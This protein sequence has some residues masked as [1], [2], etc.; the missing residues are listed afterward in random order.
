MKIRIAAATVLIAIAGT[1]GAGCSTDDAVNAVT[2][3]VAEVT[4]STAT[5]LSTA[6]RKTREA[7]TNLQQEAKT[8]PPAAL[9][10]ANATLDSV[11]SSLSGISIPEG[12][13]TAWREVVGDFSQVGDTIDSGVAGIRES[14]AGQQ[15]S[16]AATRAAE[17]AEDLAAQL[18]AV[19]SDL[20]LSC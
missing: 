15:V 9:T 8:N 13:R 20:G 12:V 6:C 2:S 19:T 5:A 18:K 16:Q 10:E 1:I 3:Q 4:G 11:R 14:G 7:A 17:G